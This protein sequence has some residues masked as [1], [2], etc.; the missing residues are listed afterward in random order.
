[1]QQLL[2]PLLQQVLMDKISLEIEQFSSP[3]FKDNQG[4]IFCRIGGD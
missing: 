4:Q 3:A 2:H 1:M